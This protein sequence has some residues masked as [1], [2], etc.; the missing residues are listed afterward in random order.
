[1][2]PHLGQTWPGISGRLFRDNLRDSQ[3]TT[4]KITITKTIINNNG[5]P[6]SPQYSA[7][8]SLLKIIN[9]IYFNG[10]YTIV[11]YGGLVYRL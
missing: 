2:L 10:K 1:L 6:I 4:A 3:I 8:I 11:L 5:I 7:I 9:T